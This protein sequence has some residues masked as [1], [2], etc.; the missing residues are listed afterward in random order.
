MQ[1]CSDREQKFAYALG[2]GLAD[3]PTEAARQAGY[4]SKNPVAVRVR[5][6]ELISRDHVV[7]AIRECATG[8]FSALIGLTVKA[9]QDIV[10]DNRHPEHAKTVL[11]ILSRLGFNEKAA[12][13][14][15]L[16]AEVKV[17]DHRQA[18]WEDFLRATEWKFPEETML[19]MFGYSGLSILRARLA[20]EK[21]KS[22]PPPI[23]VTATEV[24]P[25]AGA[26]REPTIP[27]RDRE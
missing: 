4:E 20:K 13:D 24:S 7:A 6:H 25:P 21:A 5:A 3:N 27:Y 10:R 17:V 22:L 15:N 8:T 1:Q 16:S 12:V 18:E 19:E 2:T 9:A 26:V 11:S 23:E 14:V